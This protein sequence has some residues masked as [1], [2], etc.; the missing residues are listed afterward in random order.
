MSRIFKIFGS[1][2]YE[3]VWSQLERIDFQFVKK[4]LD[5]ILNSD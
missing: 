1:K 2:I 3:S 5:N 4:R